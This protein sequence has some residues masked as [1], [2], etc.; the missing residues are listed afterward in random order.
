MDI[1]LSKLGEFSCFSLI[2]FS[3]RTAFLGFVCFIIF[4]YIFHYEHSLRISIISTAVFYS[5]NIAK[6]I[7][8]YRKSLVSGKNLI[9]KS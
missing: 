9:K 8:H 3:I 2:E 6:Y 1:K 4:H 7:Y 5:F